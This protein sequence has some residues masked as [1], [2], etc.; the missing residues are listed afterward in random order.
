[1]SVAGVILMAVGV[2]V[3]LLASVGLFILK[4]ALS[5]QHAATKAGSLGIVL[6]SQ[7]PHWWVGM[8]LGLARRGHRAAGLAD[9]AGRLARAGPCSIAQFQPGYR[10]VGVIRPLFP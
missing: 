8:G 7:A 9:H 2:F 4:D 10:C 3:L 5:R 1:M 6:S